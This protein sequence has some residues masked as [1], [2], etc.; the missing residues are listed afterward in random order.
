IVT[1][2]GRTY[3]SRMAGS[4]L[5]NVGLP[6]LVTYS[7]PDYERL[8]IQLGQNPLRVSS[9]KRY[10][11]EHGRQSPLFDIPGMVRDLETEF[12]RLALAHRAR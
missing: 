8:A 12:E 6:D 10:L 4:L 1:Y 5:T 11:A 9:Y 3:I 2:A 7:L